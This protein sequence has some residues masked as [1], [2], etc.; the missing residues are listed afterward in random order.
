[1]NI[2]EDE[3]IVKQLKEVMDQLPDDSDMTIDDFYD[4]INLEK[5]YRTD[6]GTAA[7]FKQ[8]YELEEKLKENN[9]TT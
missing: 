7:L 3:N 9:E 8:Y 5:K 1:M 6:F 4:Y 2:E